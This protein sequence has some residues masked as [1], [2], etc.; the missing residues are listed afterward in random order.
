[1]QAMRLS[2]PYILAKKGRAKLLRDASNPNISLRVIV[3]QANMLDSLMDYITDHDKQ[4]SIKLDTSNLEFTKG[5]IDS[6]IEQPYPVLKHEPEILREQEIAD[7]SYMPITSEVTEYAFEVEPDTDCDGDILSSSTSDE[8]IDDSS[9]ECKT[10]NV[11][12]ASACVMEKRSHIYTIVEEDLSMDCPSLE[13]DIMVDNF[14]RWFLQKHLISFHTFKRAWGHGI[15]P[16][17][18]ELVTSNASD[19]FIIPDNTVVHYFRH[20]R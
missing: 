3:T 8:S 1:M 15:T 7:K 6:E 5:A 14:M 18:D 11:D 2:G 12:R 13:T 9:D 19:T 4:P 20:D 17:F 16:Q 10:F